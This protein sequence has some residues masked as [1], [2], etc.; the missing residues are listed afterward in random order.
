[1]TSTDFLVPHEYKMNRGDRV[2]EL[3]MRCLECGE[4]QAHAYHTVEDAKEH[5]LRVQQAIEKVV[6]KPKEPEWKGDTPFFIIFDPDGVDGKVGI[7][8]DENGWVET[9]KENMRSAGTWFLMDKRAGRALF[10]VVTEEGDQFYYTKRHVG[11]LMAG[12]EV[13][14]YG[15][16]KKRADGRTVN[17]WLLPN[18]SVCGGDD[19][20]ILAARMI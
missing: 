14:C 18:G 10:N 7:D 8:L 6:N 16:G 15:I 1:M 11:N 17:L 5:D 13:L 20:D 2:G 9:N 3:G 12:K 4:E 19:V